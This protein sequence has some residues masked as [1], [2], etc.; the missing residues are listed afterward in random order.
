MDLKNKSS[1]EQ[2]IIK[3]KNSKFNV[4]SNNLNNINIPNKNKFKR[5]SQTRIPIKKPLKAYEILNTSCRQIKYNLEND[6]SFKDN[7]FQ[8]KNSYSETFLSNRT[9]SN[10]SRR[11][12]E[13]KNKNFLESDFFKSLFYKNSLSDGTDVNCL[14]NENEILEKEK[15][16]NEFIK[17]NLI[18]SNLNEDEINSNL[19]EEQ[20][21]DKSVY[22]NKNNK[23]NINNNS[24]NYDSCR[25]IINFKK[26]N[27]NFEEENLIR[28]KKNSIISKK[29]FKEE[30]KEFS[31]NCLNNKNN[32]TKINT[33]N[34]IIERCS[35]T[36]IDNNIKILKNFKEDIINK[37]S[38]C[39][40]FSSIMSFNRKKDLNKNFEEEAKSI[41]M[42]NRAKT[43]MY[44]HKP[45]KL[46]GSNTY[47]SILE[48][49][50]ETNSK[51]KNLS[52]ASKNSE[53]NLF[54]ESFNENHKF[55]RIKNMLKNNILL[56]NSKSKG[57]SLEIKT[58]EIDKYEKSRKLM[59]KS[60]I[61]DSLSD[62]EFQLLADKRSTFH[63][64][65][66]IKIFIDFLV[67]IVLIYSMI[68]LPIR[69]IYTESASIDNLILESVFDCIYISDFFL[70]FFI[71]FYDFEE[72]YITNKVEI[73]FNY[74]RTNFLTDLL[75]GIP[76]NSISELNSIL[77]RIDNINIL[78]INYLIHESY[79]EIDIISENN[80]QHL[81][82]D[83]GS[84]SSFL[85]YNENNYRNIFRIFRVIKFLKVI[86]KNSFLN[87]I[88]T[89]FK[90][91]YK[92]GGA[93]NRLLFFFLYFLL[94]SHI[95]TCIFI[96]LGSLKNPNWIV[97]LNLQ[98]SSFADIYV[99]S[100][101]FNHAT[102][103]TIGYG[104]VLSK[105]MY[106]R[107]YNILLMVVG[108]ALYSF[109]ITSISNIIQQQDE[110][111]KIYLK[112]MEYFSELKTK[113]SIKRKLVDKVR[114]YFK[115][116]MNSNKNDK[117][118]LLKE[119]PLNLRNEMIICMY[120]N[121]INSFV[122]FKNFS[123]LDFA[124]KAIVSFKPVSSLKNEIL[125]KEGDFLEEIIF[126]KMGVLSLEVKL[127]ISE[128]K[129]TS[130]NK[131]E[132]NSKIL[133]NVINNDE[134][135]IL[136]IIEIRENEHFGDVLIFL[137]EKSPLSV[138]T[139][140]IFKK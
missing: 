43:D 118:E 95:L 109:T 62:D 12:Q 33:K 40:N 39:N 26:K 8:K 32:K 79:K 45:Q 115:Y 15:F 24:S 131:N 36:H 94:M 99:T 128:N 6:L 138:R 56:T 140:S 46:P 96:F 87:I 113:Y 83:E 127:L 4:N 41:N 126:V 31:F 28:M 54:T 27:K 89:K 120:K 22:I 25:E 132:R 98:N 61:Y 17:N 130:Q 66:K 21:E 60:L 106:E 2:N 11:N 70:S 20:Y 37:K 111:T 102:I 136:K 68:Y 125:V 58:N 34:S 97:S 86:K 7:S 119:L 112:N 5:I 116:D 104:D 121:I 101:Y 139:R 18:N 71:G 82:S 91:E 124:I 114:R 117:N 72:N 51:E 63:P 55:N 52:Q 76:F 73:F 85:T 108:I 77:K 23:T 67:F 92:L 123:N 53:D 35:I 105:N 137:N 1:I 64:N 3:L 57:M 75:S 49:A 107:L 48:K 19:D 122:F 90:L 110:K 10:K 9:N 14:N 59:K 65:S 81:N 29:D 135:Q 93:V 74:Y 84:I 47:E 78:Y 50:K 100:L 42:L 30:S 133:D 129:K 69:L 103:F 80:N 16:L 38:M 134:S 44:K 13:Y 88:Y